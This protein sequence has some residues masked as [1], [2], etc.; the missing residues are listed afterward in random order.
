M[1]LKGITYLC[2]PEKYKKQM[3]EEYKKLYGLDK[4]ERSDIPNYKRGE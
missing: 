3:L 1:D 2:L 4:E